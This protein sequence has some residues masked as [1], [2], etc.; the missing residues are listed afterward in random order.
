MLGIHKVKQGEVFG[1]LFADVV[2]N[3]LC[4]CCLLSTR[5][6]YVST[7]RIKGE[8]VSRFLQRK[9]TNVLG[10]NCFILNLREDNSQI[11]EIKTTVINL[12][13]ETLISCSCFALR[14]VTCYTDQW[15]LSLVSVA[16]AQHLERGDYLLHICSR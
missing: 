10:V 12:N 13:A 5:V 1:C 4:T 15:P 14:V 16:P 8:I 7:N 11:S 2:I 6:V 9:Q 3:N